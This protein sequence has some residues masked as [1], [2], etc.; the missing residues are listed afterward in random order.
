M[1]KRV[2]KFR[3]WDPDAKKMI[4]KPETLKRVTYNETDNGFHMGRL[5]KT[6][7]DWVE[8]RIM[9]WTGLHDKNGK[10]I[11]EGDIFRIEEEE[12]ED[13]RVFYV[14]ITWVKEWCMFCSLLVESEYFDYLNDGI[15][16][17]DEPMFWTYTLEDTNSS[18][19]FLCGNVYQN[20]ELI[21]EAKGTV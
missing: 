8:F 10:E 11:Y 19:H 12:D 1:E 7:G 9:Q 4:Y 15:E 3:A 2:I 14:V 21:L 6:S 16:A 13:D 17:L 18:K 20:P 5:D